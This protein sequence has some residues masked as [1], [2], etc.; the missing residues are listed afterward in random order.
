MNNVYLFDFFLFIFVLQFLFM[1]KTSMLKSL[2]DKFMSVV[3][4]AFSYSNT[5]PMSY[6]ISVFTFIMLLTCCFG[7]YFS[8]AVCP[9]GLFEFTLTYALLAWLSTFLSLFSSEKFSVT[10][11]KEGDSYLKTF[12][13]LMVELVSE[14]SRPLALTVRLTVNILVGHLMVEA[15]YE[16][17]EFVL[18]SGVMLS[19][20][21]IAF[22][23]CVFF[24]QSY[25]FS[26]LVYLYL[27]E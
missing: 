4:M 10:M 2:S 6:F 21:I 16:L 22:E 14:F 3:N 7:G 1:F 25:I 9:C 13:M 5:L 24:I 17:A 8:Y 15:V 20:L 18:H 12:T 19:V 23:S 26:R 27:S 11:S